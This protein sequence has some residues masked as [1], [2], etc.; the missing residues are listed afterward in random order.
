MLVEISIPVE[1]STKNRFLYLWENGQKWPTSELQGPRLLIF[2]CEVEK[3]TYDLLFEYLFKLKE[4]DQDIYRRSPQESQVF[5]GKKKSVE[6]SIPVE[7]S[8]KNYFS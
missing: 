8:T 7:Y 5:G 1:Y 2:Y 6:I 3:K 4:L